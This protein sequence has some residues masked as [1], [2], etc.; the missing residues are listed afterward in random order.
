MKDTIKKLLK[1]NDFGWVSELNYRFFEISVCDEYDDLDSQCVDASSYWVKYSNLESGD[2]YK[3]E[4]I[5]RALQ[6]G[7]IR[8]GDVWNI[9]YVEEEDLQTYCINSGRW[10]V[11][12]F[13]KEFCQKKVNESNDFDWVGNVELLQPN[14]RYD[15]KVNETFWDRA[16]TYVGEERGHYVFKSKNGTSKIPIESVKR[17]IEKGLVRPYDPNWSPYDDIEWGTLDDIEGRNFAI[18]FESGLSIEETKPIQ[19][20]LFEKGFRFSSKPVGE[21]MTDVSSPIMSFESIN[22]D[23]SINRYKSLP[24]TMRDDKILLVSTFD[25]IWGNESKIEST[26]N[27]FLDNNCVVIDGY[28]LLRKPIKEDFDWIKDIPSVETG[29]H[30]TEEDVAFE[31]DSGYEVNMLKGK[32]KYNLG[33]EKFNELVLGNYDDYVLRTLISTNGHFQNHY[34]DDYMDDDEINY[35][36][37]YLTDEQLVRLTKLLRR[38][39]HYK[40]AEQYVA[41]SEFRQLEDIIGDKFYKGR[42]DWDDFTQDA[43]SEISIA[44]ERNRWNSLGETYRKTLEDNHVD[45]YSSNDWYGKTHYELT[46]PYPYINSNGVEY[47]NLSEILEGPVRD[48]FDDGWQDML[49]QGY[50]STG[51]DEGIQNSFNYMIDQLEERMDELDEEGF[52]PQPEPDPNQLKLNFESRLRESN[53]FDW[54]G[55]VGPMEPGMEFLKDNFDDLKLVVRGDESYYVDSEGRPFFIYNPNSRNNW[56]WVYYDKIWSVLEKDFRLTNHEVKKLITVWLNETH[57]ITGFVPV[58]GDSSLFD[59]LIKK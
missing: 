49:Y 23:T 44:L 33:E 31:D 3:D 41:D 56:I 4:V 13:D 9:N 12:D 22:W 2:D 26:V 10:G 17:L 54:V 46:V 5:K 29:E 50:D 35:L 24:P 34:H 51:A 27:I 15:I 52:E 28:D 42:W 40:S 19:D 43:L 45:L 1:E 53:D 21:H 8:K 6:D 59:E 20:I 11:D 30:F 57:N 16:L 36:G 32:V 58:P 7:V 14:G 37:G 39:G 18:F 25:D 55:D 47:W 38:K 48:I